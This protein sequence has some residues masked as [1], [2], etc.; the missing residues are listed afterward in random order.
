M[1]EIAKSS[2]RRKVGDLTSK[3]LGI[4]DLNFIGMVNNCAD[5]LRNF[6]QI[7]FLPHT[8]NHQKDKASRIKHF[9]EGKCK[10]MLNLF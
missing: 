3:F 5:D 8:L 7:S 2:F 4:N 9:S 10:N 6:K 1:K